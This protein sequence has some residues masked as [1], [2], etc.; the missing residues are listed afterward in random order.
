[1]SQGDAGA[2][3]R[4]GRGFCCFEKGCVVGLGRPLA[5][6]VIPNIAT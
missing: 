1:M 3:C 2:N 4:Q 6:V 5:A